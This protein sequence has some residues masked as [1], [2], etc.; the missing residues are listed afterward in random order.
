MPPPTSREGASCGVIMSVNNSL[1]CGP[2]YKY[3]TAE[4]KEHWLRPFA[5]GEKL[6]CFALSEPGNGSDAGAASCTATRDGDGWVLNGTKSW[7]TNGPTADATVVFATTDKA[8]KHRGITAFLVDGADFSRGKP[9]DKLGIRASGTCNLIFEN[10]RVPGANVLGSEG[11]GFK[12]AMQTL[13][14]GRIGI[15]AQALGIAQAALECAVKYSQERHSMGS[16]LSKIQVY[17]VLNTPFC[18]AFLDVRKR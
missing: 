9:E 12:I 13:Y 10:C 18:S 15:A 4:Q 14:S 7:I 8:A 2:V 6:G 5:S 11:G 1:Y 16:P 3:G 17:R